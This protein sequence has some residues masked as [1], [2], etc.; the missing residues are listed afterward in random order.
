MPLIPCIG[1]WTNC[2]LTAFGSTWFVWVIF[3]V[4]EGF[5]ILFYVC[6]GRKHS[7]LRRRIGKHEAAKVGDVA[8]AAQDLARGVEFG[9][10]DKLEKMD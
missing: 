6:Y 4:F 2:V 8:G 10:D 7:K 9:E 3:A 1:I 5:G